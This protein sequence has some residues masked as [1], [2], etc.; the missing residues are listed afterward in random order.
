MEEGKGWKRR[1]VDKRERKG[2]GRG[3]GSL[4][5]TSEQRQH[6]LKRAHHQE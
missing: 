3:R 1:E 4:A 6:I 5:H 2:E